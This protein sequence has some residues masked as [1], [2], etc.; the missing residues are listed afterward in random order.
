MEYEKL[1]AP[2]P[3]ATVGGLIFN[4]EGKILLVRT[5]KWSDLLGT[6]G[7]KMEYGETM[8]AAFIREAKEETNLDIFDLEFIL[9]QDAYNHPEF[10]RP[11]HFLLINFTARTHS[12]EVILNDEAYAYHWVGL[13]ESLGLD[14]NQPTR[15]LVEAVIERQVS[16]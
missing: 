5:H 14:L 7:G 6:P 12:T 13:E 11:S 8:E 2:R 9:I 1:P 16:L 15:V 4:P 3:L 10:Y